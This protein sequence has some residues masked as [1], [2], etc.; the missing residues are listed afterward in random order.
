MN[1]RIGGLIQAYYLGKLFVQR[2]QNPRQSR[3]CR[4][5]STKHYTRAA[6]RVYYLF[7]TL[8]TDRIYSTKSINYTSFTLISQAEFH[9]LMNETTMIVTGATI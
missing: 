6:L 9:Q 8:G 7:E 4:K 3:S 5:K 2:I 1:D